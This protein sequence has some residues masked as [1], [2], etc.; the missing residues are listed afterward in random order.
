[1]PDLPGN[2]AVHRIS[3]T[4]FRLP[5]RGTLQWGKH[6]AMAEARHVL[7]TVVLDDGS[8]GVAE[9]PP[10]PTI[11]GETAH[12]IAHII[13]QE[14]APR[15]E[16]RP[17][18]EAWA[19]MQAIKYNYAAKAAVDMALHDAVAHSR[20][21]SL[22]EHLGSTQECLR[23]S[24][25]LGIGSPD[26][27]IA[28][29]HHVVEQG[30][31]VL[32]VKVGR[33]WDDD[34]RRVDELRGLLGPEVALYADANECM[35]P[36][37]AA[38]KLDAL[39]ERG[40]LYCEEPLPVEL[41]R[42]RAALRAGGHLPLI[43]DDSAFTLRDLRR[44]LALDTFDVLNIKTART[45]YTESAAMLATARAAGKGVMVGSQASAG[46]GTARAA[47]VAALPEVDHPSELSFFLKLQEDIIDRAIPIV[48]GHI[49]LDD[50]AGVAVDPERLRAVEVTEEVTE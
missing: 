2:L 21:V 46:L 48:D 39:R 28:E 37:D 35:E 41:V 9:A 45:G 14:L 12:T 33:D 3:T 17:A 10:R 32:K 23:V 13:A 25:I 50:L 47:L 15:V 16:G 4:V 29:A 42:E 8:T 20:G 36:E 6:G 1:M 26:E 38:R 5:L 11:Y 7:V 49:R 19:L 31:R 22:A 43:A 27:V 24:Y 44:E 18:N 40:L 30:V 34:L